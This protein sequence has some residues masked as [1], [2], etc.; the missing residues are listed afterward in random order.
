[1]KRSVV[2]SVFLRLFIGEIALFDIPHGHFDGCTAQ[3]GDAYHDVRLSVQLKQFAPQSAQRTF[4]R[5][6]HWRVT[7]CTGR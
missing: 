7:S 5:S 3:L 2:R 6:L 4:L 1:M